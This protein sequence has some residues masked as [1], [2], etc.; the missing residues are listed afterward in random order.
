MIEI[1]NC[2]QGSNE[3]RQHRAGIPTASMFA[4]VMAQGW[5]KTES[6]TRRKYMLQLIGERMTGEP[7]E[8]YS[9]HHMERGKIMEA[10]ARDMY[11]FMTDTDIEQIGFIRNG[12]KG[13]SPDSLV[14]ND[15][16]LEI[17]TKLP[18]LHFEVL[19]A[20][21]LPPEHTAQ[22]QGQIWTAEKEWCDFMSY[23]PKLKPF[24]HRVY[25]DEDYIKTLHSAVR[26]FNDEM[27]ELEQKLAA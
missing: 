13:C 5:G 9:N 22:V 26:Q 16:L 1:F 18:H 11:V 8:T 12:E 25:R 17:K 2:E 20:N 7:M 10:E 27:L 3:W 21:K 6:K 23:W 19:L 4:T 24:I 14:T 15:G